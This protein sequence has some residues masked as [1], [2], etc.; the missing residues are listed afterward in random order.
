MANILVIDGNPE[1]QRALAGLIQYRTTHS[2]TLAEDCVEGVR[3]V[4]SGGTDLIMINVLMFMAGNFAFSRVLGRNSRAAS[5]P[6]LV[7]TSRAL[8]DLTRRLVQVHGVAG[9]VELPLSGEELSYMIDQAL[10]KGRPPDPGDGEIR[11]VEWTRVDRSEEPKPEDG[12]RPIRNVD[13]RTHRSAGA[14]PGAT[15]AADFGGPSSTNGRPAARSTPPSGAPP[16][17]RQAP[18]RPNR[19]D[20]IR[21]TGADPVGPARTGPVEP[22]EADGGEAQE[23][24]GARFR[25]IEWPS[26]DPS[27]VKNR[28]R[29]PGQDGAE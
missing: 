13:W 20:P 1:Q 9:F 26:A 14:E 8:E 15:P 16:G 3:A 21:P 19:A 11:T 12:A 2:Y 28:P 25:G 24:G 23:G 7:H 6:V 4:A 10:A 18:I 29:G 17:G 27:Q 22:E 5:L